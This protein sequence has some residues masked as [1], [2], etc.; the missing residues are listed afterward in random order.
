MH[1]DI[2]D[3]Y[4]CTCDMYLDIN[5]YSYDMYLYT[6]KYISMCV[7][8]CPLLELVEPM[9]LSRLHAKKIMIPKGWDSS[10]SSTALVGWQFPPWCSCRSSHT[11]PFQR[12]SITSSTELLLL[13]PCIDKGGAGRIFVGRL[14]RNLAI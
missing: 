4:L 3:M 8:A 12:C 11:L 9:V 2:C 13:L 10:N 1:R 7:C 6:S 5:I 14:V